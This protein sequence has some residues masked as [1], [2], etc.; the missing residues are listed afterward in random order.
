MKWAA[1]AKQDHRIKSGAMTVRIEATYV[2]IG[3][4][5]APDRDQAVSRAL[6]KWGQRVSVVRSLASLAVDRQG[7]F[8]GHSKP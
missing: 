3:L 2:L 5:E 8:R 6:F 1:F 4:V 7:C